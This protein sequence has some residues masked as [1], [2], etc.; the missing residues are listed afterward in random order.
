VCEPAGERPR[1]RSALR[2]RLLRGA[3]Q[4][5]RSA[6]VMFTRMERSAGELETNV[7]ALASAFVPAV[8]TDIRYLYE[9][10]WGLSLA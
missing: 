2:E 1:S 3:R 5:S 4:S 6:K 9:G 8:G 7:A 10:E